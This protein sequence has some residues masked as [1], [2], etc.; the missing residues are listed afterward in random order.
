MGKEAR[1]GNES[2]RGVRRGLPR[3]VKPVAAIAWLLSVLLLAACGGS[4]PSSAGG[5]VTLEFAQWWA[6]EMPKGSLQKIVD[7]FEKQNPNI[8][9]KLLSQPYSTLQQQTTANAATGTL[10]D[11]IGLDGAWVNDLT[12]LNAL[13]NLSDLMKDANYS[14]KDLASQLQIDGSTYMI[15]VVNFTYP[16]FTNDA[17]LAKAGI[18][19]PPKTREEFLADAK[20]ISK[21]DGTKGWIIPLGTTNPNGAKNDVM[22]WLWAAG[23]RMLRDGKPNLVNNP[24]VTDTVNFI[25]SLYDADTLAEGTFTLQETDKMNQFTNGQV[26]M[27]IDSLAHITTIQESNPKL[28]FHVSALP[29]PSGYSGKSGLN[30]ASWGIGVSQ[31]SKHK[32]EAWKFIQYLLSQTT[33]SQMATLAN[34]FP[35]NKTSKP[36]LSKATSQVKMAFKIYSAGEPVDEFSGLPKANELMRDFDEE[37]Q[38]TLS[39]K[40]SVDQMLRNTQDQWGGELK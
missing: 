29:I 21:L 19:R 7:G 5:K 37:F 38:R 16:L 39:G 27:M 35:G 26:G 18:A 8:T 15:P 2:Q 4:G 32:A 23:G 30:Y 13:A 24:D 36:D 34:G 20:K 14:G 6:P 31:K 33:N 10:S 3:L 11:V 28:K 40:Q 22:S 17:I 1:V 25:K 9:V 12:K